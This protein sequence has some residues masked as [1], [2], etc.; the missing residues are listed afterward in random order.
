M[1]KNKAKYIASVVEL[2]ILFIL[3]T[4]LISKSIGKYFIVDVKRDYRAKRQNPNYAFL[5]GFFGKS[6][7]EVFNG[8]VGQKVTILFKKFLSF[9]MPIFQIFQKIFKAFQNSI[10]KIRNL[11]KP[12]REFIKAAAEKFYSSISKYVIGAVYSLNKIRNS[13][14]RT[15]SGFNLIFHTLEHSKNSLQSIIQSPPVKIAMALMEPIEWVSDSA[16]KLFCFGGYTPLFDTNRDLIFMQNIKVGTIL[17]N[18]SVVIAKQ[19][20]IYSGNNNSNPLYLYKNNTLATG[21]HKVYENNKWIYIKDSK[22]AK[23][24]DS[25]PLYI[26]CITSSKGIIQIYNNKFKDY[27]ESNN[28]YVNLTVNS[29][30]LSYLNGNK[31]DSTIY[32]YGTDY[33]E[34]GFAED[35][36]IQT[37]SEF[38]KIKDL[39]IGDFLNPNNKVL[40]IVEL[41]TKSFSFYNINDIIVSSNT[42]VYEDNIWKNIE[43]SRKAKKVVYL[44]KCYN[45]VTSSGYI[46][47]NNQIFLDYTESKDPI[48][49]NT[50]DE[51]IDNIID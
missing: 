16:N 11:L 9:L 5:G 21:E 10:N 12:I 28:T 34:H 50:I 20:F 23:L 8:I 24:S 42:K 47:T 6:P 44:Y 30:I 49:N 13:M 17:E 37:E 7:L 19:Q 2:L 4:Y 3:A 18:G 1:D 51:I 46:Y 22:N 15:M 27:S 33:L 38:K 35:T 40:G 45:I 25:K 41:N 48:L 29:L 32:A 39:K 14:R 31:I 43:K 36:L 26:Y